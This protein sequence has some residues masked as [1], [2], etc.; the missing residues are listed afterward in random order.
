MINEDYAVEAG[1]VAKRVLGKCSSLVKQDAGILDIAEKVEGMIVDADVGIAFPVNI[2][3]DDISAHDTARINDGRV[4]EKGM[5]VKVDVGVHVNGIIAD[6]ARTF[7]VGSSEHRS[8]ISLVEECAL[9]GVMKIKPG[10][11][12]RDVGREIDGIIEG[13]GFNVVE[14]LVGHGLGLFNVHCEPSIQNFD[15]RNSGIFK[16]GELVAVEPYL[17]YGKGF[18][19]NSPSCEIFSLERVKPVRVFK[20]RE[21]LEWIKKERTTLP[22]C[23]RW[24]SSYGSQLDFLL[25]LLVKEGVLHPYPVLREISGEK[26]AQAEHTVLI[27][28]NPIVTTL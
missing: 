13:S 7:E 15:G 5:V 26:V 25:N 27:K 6:T 17:T 20:A 4:L 19:V 2:S 1:R 23:K 28:D 9:K 8:I 3:I 14:N 18:C 10:S 12:I 21:I 24:L 16:S 22:F 11:R